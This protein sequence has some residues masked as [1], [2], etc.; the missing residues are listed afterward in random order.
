MKQGYGLNPQQVL[1]GRNLE[2]VRGYYPT[3]CQ[4]HCLPALH[5]LVEVG[6]A[7]RL[8]PDEAVRDICLGD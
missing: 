7:L 8:L 5:H 1:P 3:G 6:E 4:G 2:N